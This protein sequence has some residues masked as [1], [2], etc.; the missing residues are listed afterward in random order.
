[1]YDLTSPKVIRAL[2]NEYGFKFKKSYG[3]NFLT[4]SDVLYKIAEIAGEEGVL[5]IGPGFGTLTAFLA[6]R[7]K[8]V[9]AI[10][11]DESLKPIID[12]TLAGFNNIDIVYKDIM[13]TDIRALLNEYFN[14][15]SVSVAANLPY[16]VT[17]PIVLK[18]LE[19]RLP[20]KKVI[21]MVQKEVG[22]R[23]VAKPGTKDYGALTIAVDY[24]SKA[25]IIEK[26]PASSFIPAPK[27]DSCVVSMEIR[28][29]PYINADEKMFFSVVKA[30]FAQRRKTLSNGLANSGLF[31]TKENIQKLIEELGYD[32]NV[33]GETL[34]I[35]EFSNIARLLN[36]R[37]Y[38]R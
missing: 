20:F 23:M 24:Y 15:M 38:L 22:D 18:L 36:E 19:E 16:Y 8:K 27:V 14:G 12:T 28:T 37:G 33:R 34:S 2:C 4:D 35:I 6:Q 11:L 26:V 5:E 7:S 21:V 1:M 9:L 13:K 10:E 17:T 25:E 32:G 30:A 31:G 29:E 3:Q